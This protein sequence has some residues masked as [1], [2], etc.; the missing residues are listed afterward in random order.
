MLLVW[1]FFWVITNYEITLSINIKLLQ[2]AEAL[3]HD[4]LKMKPS[5]DS[6]FNI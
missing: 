1:N 5:S 6:C 4:N 3:R 2:R